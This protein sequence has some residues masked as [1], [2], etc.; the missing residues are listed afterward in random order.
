MIWSFVA[1]SLGYWLAAF[2]STSGEISFSHVVFFIVLSFTCGQVISHLP[3]LTRPVF[4]VK[5]TGMNSSGLRDITTYHTI[6]LLA[7]LG[8]MALLV[9]ILL[10]LLL[11]YCRFVLN[12][13]V[14]E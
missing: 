4:C 12:V 9:L 13:C 1:P 10:C 5:G 8:A 14:F 2:P 7:I 11:Y 3:G 6:F